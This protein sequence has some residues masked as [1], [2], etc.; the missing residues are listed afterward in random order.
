LAYRNYHGAGLDE[1]HAALCTALK[2]GSTS[3]DADRR[4]SG[5][6]QP[7]S[8]TG[9]LHPTSYASARQKRDGHAILE[10]RS[11]GEEDAPCSL[12]RRASSP[13][14]MSALARMTA[15]I[16]AAPRA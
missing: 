13:L 2:C 4:A 14:F 6:P 11:A 16:E 5:R 8:A 1:F 9:G 10:S 15:R 7:T 12:K 3:V